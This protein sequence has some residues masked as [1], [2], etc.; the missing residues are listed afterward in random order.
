MEPCRTSPA[1]N[2]LRRDAERAGDRNGLK[3]LR[4]LTEADRVDY[5]ETNE[6]RVT[7]AGA[8]RLNAYRR[9]GDGT[10]CHPA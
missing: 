1:A 8:P 4:L 10:R 2:R 5:L 3:A 6:S 9:G 7:L